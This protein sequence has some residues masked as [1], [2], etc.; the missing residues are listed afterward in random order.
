MRW[1]PQTSKFAAF[2][3]KKDIDLRSN[4]KM[5]YLGAASGSTASHLSKILADGVIYAVEF[6]WK[7]MR[8]LVELSK[9]EKNIIPLFFDANRPEEYTPYVEMVDFIYQDIAQKNQVEIA[10]KNAEIFLARGGVLL[11]M[12]KT[13]SIDAVEETKK[14]ASAEIKRLDEKFNIIDVLK[15][16]PFYKDHVAILANYDHP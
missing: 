16:D 7:P 2:L 12:L 15:L 5:L 6:S 1:N 3:I 4:T 9:G 8:K 11:L 10:N 14:I 13:R